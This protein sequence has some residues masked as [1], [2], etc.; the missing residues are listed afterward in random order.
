[1]R[2]CAIVVWLVVA[3]LAGCGGGGDPGDG[4]VFEDPHGTVDVEEGARFSL[5][6][7]VNAGVGFDWEPVGVP[8][9]VALVELK[10]TKVDYPDERRAGDSGKKRFVY[11]ATR[12]GRQT[13]VFRRIYRGDPQQRR[14]I[15]VNVR[16]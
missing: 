2:R 1:M 15:T 12:A 11:E 14:T 8:A 5:E 3:L 6:F 4:I 9:G 7:S 16:G 13:L 10:E